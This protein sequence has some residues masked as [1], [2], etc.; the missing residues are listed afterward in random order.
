MNKNLK[1]IQSVNAMV[2]KILSIGYQK[3]IQGSTISS[4]QNI[5]CYAKS[6]N[7]SGSYHIAHYA[8]SC[9]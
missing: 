8:G 7:H 4:L 3:Y 6:S 1:W 2:F 5:Y 9:L